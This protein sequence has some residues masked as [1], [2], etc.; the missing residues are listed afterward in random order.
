MTNLPFD[1][2][3][4]IRTIILALAWLNQFL[5]MNGHSPLPFDNAQTE[6][7][8][9]SFVTFCASIWNWWKNNDVT[10]KA[11]LASELAKREGLK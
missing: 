6:M 2:G 5:V 11:R 1:K 7:G 3:M 4:I 9:T 8:V 10:R